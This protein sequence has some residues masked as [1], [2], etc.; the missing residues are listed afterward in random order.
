[1]GIC[2]LILDVALQNDFYVNCGTHWEKA[3]SE[4]VSFYHIR[5]LGES[6]SNLVEKKFWRVFQKYFLRAKRNILGIIAFFEK[7]AF[8]SHFCRQQKKASAVRKSFFERYCHKGILYVN[9]NDLRKKVQLWKQFCLFCLFQTRGDI[10][11]TS[12]KNFQHDCR[13]CSLRVHWHTLRK[14]IFLLNKKGL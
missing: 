13:N 8:C 2:R 6:L 10:F 14:T 9:W 3:I 12:A 5:I 11:W 1:M 4:K 7:L